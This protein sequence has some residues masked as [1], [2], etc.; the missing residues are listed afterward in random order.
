MKT[1]EA[2][3]RDLLR[4]AQAGEAEAFDLLVDR[5]TP[6]L[7]RTVRRLASDGA[8]A[9]AI[10]QEAWL[11][12]WK[13]RKGLDPD[14]PALAW[15]SRIAVNAARDQW[16]KRRPL[17]FSDTGEAAEAQADERAGPELRL[18][19]AEARTRLAQVVGRLRPEWRVVIAL[20]YD[21]GLAY[22]EI[23]EV[24]GIPVNTVRT[25]LHRAHAA[26]QRHLEG[27]PDA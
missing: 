13:H 26:L 18:E 21:G 5:L 22:S 15:L 25:H 8:E 14:R 10:V 4:R 2:V 27:V 23:A 12:A 16:R 11:R 9:E 24:L 6:L 17:D 19:E 7:Y 3:D 20:R 1:G